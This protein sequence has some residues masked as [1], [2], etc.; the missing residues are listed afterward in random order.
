[1]KETKIE[2]FKSKVG[3]ENKLFTSSITMI[4]ERANTISLVYTKVQRI[5]RKAIERH[6]EF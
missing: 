4:E 2:R 1:M 5:N 3:M 6:S